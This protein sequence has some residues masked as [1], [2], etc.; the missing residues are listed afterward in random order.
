MLDN[1]V[2]LVVAVVAGAVAA[3]TGFGIAS[4]LTPVLALIAVA[5]A[6]V[7]AFLSRGTRVPAT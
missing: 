4:L 5:G 6:R 2:V 1:T 7:P 3:V